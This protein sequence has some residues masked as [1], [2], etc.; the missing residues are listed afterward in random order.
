MGL[1]VSAGEGTGVEIR[2]APDFGLLDRAPTS[3]GGCYKRKTLVELHKARQGYADAGCIRSR[4]PRG[5]ALF[6]W[7]LNTKGTE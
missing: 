1:H 2:I 6:L 5:G 7:K 3:V 4:L